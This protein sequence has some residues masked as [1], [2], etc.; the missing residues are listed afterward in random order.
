MKQGVE[1]E[2][3]KKRQAFCRKN[4]KWFILVGVA[5]AISLIILA[6]WIVSY[7]T[8]RTTLNLLKLCLGDGISEDMTELNIPSERCNEPL[9][10]LLNLSLFKN[11]KKVTVGDEAMM[12]VNNVVIGDLPNLETIEIGMNSFTTAKESYASLNRYFS[13]YNCPSLREVKIGSFSFSD[14]ATC[15]ISK[16]PRLQLIQIGELS[17]KGYNFVFSSLQLKGRG[18]KGN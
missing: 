18:L 2:K 5:L 10:I 12:Y 15:S 4:L 7:I 16:V 11:L 9:I 17:K 13:L 6:L 1:R 3:R 8:D 14:F